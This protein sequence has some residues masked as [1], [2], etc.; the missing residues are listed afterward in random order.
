MIYF[1]L[2]LFTFYFSGL[3]LGV[4]ETG[5]LKAIAQSTGRTISQVKSDAQAQGDLG[6]VA[7]QSKNKQKTMFKPQP[8]MVESVYTKLKV[9]AKMSGHTVSYYKTFYFKARHFSV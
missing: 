7:E 9:I 6:I 1:Q 2:S 8:L 3:E 5:L 4:A